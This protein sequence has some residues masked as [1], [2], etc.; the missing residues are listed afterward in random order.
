MR[1]IV[2]NNDAVAVPIIN[3]YLTW[4]KT[5]CWYGENC[6]NKLYGRLGLRLATGNNNKR[7]LVNNVLLPE[8]AY[9]CCYC[10]RHIDDYSDDASIEH[11]IPQHTSS[12]AEMNHYFSARSNGLNNRNVCLTPN[13]VKRGDVG[14]P[15]PHHVAYHNF[16]VACRECNRNRGRYEI[17]PLF[18]Y[19][20]IQEEV[21]YNR[22][23]GEVE[24]VLDP[25]YS[26]LEPELPTLEKVG[27]NRPLLKAIRAVWFYAKRNKLQPATA[28][29]DELIYGTVGDSLA[30]N[31]TMSDDD[32]NAYLNLNTDEIWNLLLKYDYFK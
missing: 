11:I 7:W 14:A 32:L 20:G 19:A 22:N 17:E 6:G 13:Y 15:Y 4:A 25:V 24:W 27:A 10:M 16:A 30:V 29:R 12:D 28:N 3:T 18:L 26:S 8:Q 1:T 23:T 9:C 5:Q 2:K 31:P 21:T